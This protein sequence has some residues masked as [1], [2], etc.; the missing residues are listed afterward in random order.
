MKYRKVK[1]SI[2]PISTIKISHKVYQEITT[3]EAIFQAWDEFIKG[4]KK[5]EDVM[6]FGRFLEDNLFSLQESLEKKT[7]RHGGYKS[8]YV[9]DPKVRH[10]AKACVR[11]R[12]VHHLTT[13]MLEEIFDPTFYPHSYSCRK[14]KGTHRAVEEFVRMARQASNNNTSSCFVLKCDIKK[15]FATVDHNVLIKT[16]EERIQD[17]EFL[18]LLDEI[19]SSFRS[20]YTVELF[21]PKGMPIGNLTS[22]LFAN[23]Y[24]NSLDI[25]MKK[26]LKLKY[27]IRYADD[28]VILSNNQEYLNE[29]LPKIEDFI[30]KNLKMSL[31]PNKIE[32]CNYYLGIDFLGYLVFPNF[33]IPRTKT[34][35]RIIRKLEKKI[36]QLQSGDTTT[37]SLNQ[38]LQSYLGYLQHANAYKL[39]ESLKNK[40]LFLGVFAT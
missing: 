10:I 14:N 35:R 19:I 21:S 28:F 32:L 13:K 11:D 37:K 40:I 12:V 29:L 36:R 7:Y 31:H 27:Y 20:E 5:K 16:L 34:K 24:L 38:T 23:I 3:P 39:S 22:Q 15:F 6:E 4:K 18:W 26:D 17:K 2:W 25:F 33:I 1:S 9:R 8:F 30:G